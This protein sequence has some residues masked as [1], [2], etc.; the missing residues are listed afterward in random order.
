MIHSP[1]PIYTVDKEP[2]V[3][4]GGVFKWATTRF[5]F[6]PRLFP[7]AIDLNLDHPHGFILTQPLNL[8]PSKPISLSDMLG[9][10]PPQRNSNLHQGGGD[11]TS[12]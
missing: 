9:T 12:E 2:I 1:Q 8:S 7:E 4:V 10:P 5:Q 3:I 11:E 6:N